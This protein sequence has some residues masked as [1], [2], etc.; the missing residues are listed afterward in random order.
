MTEQRKV[1][2]ARTV[3]RGSIIFNSQ[4]S[5][6]DCLVRNFSEVGAKI[7]VGETLSFPQK[8]ELNVP[9]KGRSYNAMVIWRAGEEVGIAF[10]S[11]I[12]NKTAIP[13]ESGD[14]GEQLRELEKENAKLKLLVA[15]LKVQVERNR[16]AG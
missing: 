4:N 2:R 1:T 6:I 11:E 8:F 5:T 9:Q 16:E 3:Y 15:D 7:I 12:V 14:L 13:L 10:Q